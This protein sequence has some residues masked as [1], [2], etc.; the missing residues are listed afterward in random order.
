MNDPDTLPDEIREKLAEL[1]LELSEGDITKKGYD[2]KRDALLAPFRNLQDTAA[3]HTE[4]STA[5][6]NSRSN[7]RNQRRVTRDEDRYH[8]EIRVEAVHQALAEYS[9]GRKLGPQPVKP[10]RRNGAAV[11]RSST[12][13]NKRATANGG[14]RMLSGGKIAFFWVVRG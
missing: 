8:S 6:P 2:K 5:S 7:R 1:D 10:H 3:L 13:K 9:D 14:G 11:S 4:P 12:Q